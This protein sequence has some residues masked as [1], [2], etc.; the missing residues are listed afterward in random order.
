MQQIAELCVTL[1]KVQS[2]YLRIQEHPACGGRP[3]AVTLWVVN[4]DWLLVETLG[5]EPVV[6][7]QGRQVKNFVPLGVFLRRNP[8]LAAIQTAI[9]ETVATG[10]GLASITPKTNRVIRTE[11][12][13]MTDGR[14]HGVHVWCGSADVE[15]VERPTAGVY[16]ADL[17]LSEGSVTTD[18]LVNTGRDPAVEKLTGRSLVEDIPIRVVNEGEAKALS[19]SIDPAPGRTF[20]ATWVW[21]DPT[22]QFRRVGF[23]FRIILEAMEDGSEHL[24]A[25]AM[26]VVES[27]G[28]PTLP[29]D[30][31]ARRILDG[32]AQPGVHRAIVDLNTWTLLKW[33]DEPCPYYDWRVHAQMHPDDHRLLSARMVDELRSGVTSAVLRLPANGGGWTPVHVTI[34]QVELDDGIYAGILSLRLPSDGELAESGLAAEG[35]VG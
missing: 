14:V 4:R 34:H 2:I 3:A 6:V 32:M 13:V 30:H 24:I 1:S 20:S 5:E 27:V 22:G 9:A 23:C 19:W 17:A 16:K 28:E 33:L 26:N 18:F 11:P 7:G 10:N 25:R 29:G 31:L 15:P 21:K 35:V 12:V 8:N